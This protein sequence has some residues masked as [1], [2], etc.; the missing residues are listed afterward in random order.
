[1]EW[2][3]LGINVNLTKL[4]QMHGKPSILGQFW[5]DYLYNLNS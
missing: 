3:S 5:Q 2:H 4:D 1:M